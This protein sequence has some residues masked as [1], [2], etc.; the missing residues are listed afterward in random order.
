MDSPLE[1][2]LYFTS[3][4][5]KMDQPLRL[6]REDHDHSKIRV[7][8]ESNLFVSVYSNLSSPPKCEV[9]R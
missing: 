6:T 9:F 8:I 4:G 3:Y 5:T 7:D 2:H 1:N